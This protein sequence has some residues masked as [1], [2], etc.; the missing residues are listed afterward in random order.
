[1]E[2]KEVTSSTIKAVGYDESIKLLVVEFIK[3]GKYTYNNVPKNVY[4]DFMNA[5]S[6][7]KY[8]AQ[9]IKQTYQ[10]SKVEC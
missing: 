6:Q 3:G 2:L 1:M 10:Y 9:N 8:F 7:G 4:E 5:E